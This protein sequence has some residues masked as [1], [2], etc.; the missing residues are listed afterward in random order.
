[1]NI[2]AGLARDLEKLIGLEPALA[3]QLQEAGGPDQAI[4]QIQTAAGRH[5]IAIDAGELTELLQAAQAQ[6]AAGE[7]T[8]DQLAGVDG[9]GPAIK[10]VLTLINLGILPIFRFKP[11]R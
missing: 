8:D 3:R 2:N 1:M 4:E 9:G 10:L 11:H 6:A 5:G 7:L